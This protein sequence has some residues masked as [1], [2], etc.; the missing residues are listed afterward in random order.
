MGNP[1]DRERQIFFLWEEE[2]PLS[3]TG[4]ISDSDINGE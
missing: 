1:R 4:D 3:D 2:V